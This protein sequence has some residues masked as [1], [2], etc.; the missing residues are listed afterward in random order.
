MT[1]WVYRTQ[2]GQPHWSSTRSIAYSLGNYEITVVRTEEHAA[3]MRD[4]FTMTADEW[5]SMR[6]RAGLPMY[7]PT[8]ERQR[9]TRYGDT[10]TDFLIQA[11][12]P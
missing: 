5:C 1:V 7:P 2:D 6:I 9:D 11:L 4:V 10:V 3:M 8:T 12:Q